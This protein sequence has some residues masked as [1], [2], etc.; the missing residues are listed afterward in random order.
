MATEKTL[1]PTSRD[2]RSHRPQTL[3]LP[4]SAVWRS[5]R[6]NNK[7]PEFAVYLYRV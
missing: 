7:V 4:L 6:I 5:D 2:C 3:A 1:S